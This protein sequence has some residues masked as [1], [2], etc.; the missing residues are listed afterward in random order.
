MV[1]SQAMGTEKGRIVK[2]STGSFLDPP[3]YPTHH[4]SVETDLR[5]RPENRGSMSLTY[6]AKEASWLDG[7]TRA[8]A[9]A[10][11][12]AWKKERPPLHSPEIQDWIHQVLGYFRGMYRNPS[13]TAEQWNASS[14]ISDSNRDPIKHSRD[15][16]G[17][18]LIHQYYPEYR[19]T[20]E[21]F[22][23]AYWGTK[24]SADRRARA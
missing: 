7:S 6:A 19:P 3:G 8:A 16:A 1:F 23:K 12:N 24:P 18:H 22:A 10:L 21:D 13:A 14:M 15:H 20:R 5:R 2:G 11:L 17:V 4:F 9:R